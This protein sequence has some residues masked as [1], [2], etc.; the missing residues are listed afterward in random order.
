M[1]FVQCLLSGRAAIGQLDT[2]RNGDVP[3]VN[4]QIEDADLQEVAVRL[5]TNRCHRR[6][7][8]NRRVER[9]EVGNAGVGDGRDS[10][11]ELGRRHRRRFLHE[12]GGDAEVEKV[13]GVGYPPRE[14]FVDPHGVRDTR[15]DIPIGTQRLRGKL[16]VI[17]ASDH[18]REFVVGDA[19]GGGV[20]SKRRHGRRP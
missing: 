17:K 18:R 9:L 13:F 5:R 12:L 2:E 16:V 6:F 7:V 15:T 19:V 3:V 10:G 8:D 20:V 14:C 1:D 4:P 11:D